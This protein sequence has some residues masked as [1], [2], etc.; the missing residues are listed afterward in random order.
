MM[1][2]GSPLRV[3]ATLDTAN[4]L[5]YAGFDPVLNVH[6]SHDGADTAL[7]N[8]AIAGGGTAT[9]PAAGQ[10]LSVAVE[11]C[12][13]PAPGGPAPLTQIHF[14]SLTPVAG[15]GA[16]VDVTSQPFDLPVCG[17]ATTT[18]AIASASTVTRYTPVNM[19]VGAGGYVD[20]N[21]EGGFDPQFYPSGVRYEVIGAVSGS[22]MPSYI[23][24]GGTNNGDTLSPTSLTATNGLVVNPNEELMLQSTLGTGSDA[25]PLCPGGGAGTTGGGSGSGGGS[26]TPPH[27]HPLPGQPGGPPGVVVTPRTESVNGRRTRVALFCARRDVPCRGTLTLTYGTLTLATKQF[28]SK[29]LATAHIALRLTPAAAKLV[30]SSGPSGLKTTMTVTLPGDTPVG[31]TITLRAR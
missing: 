31:G 13:E 22:A 14:Q 25:T 26:G 28:T 30:R 20:F 11:G 21:D 6:V 15:G 4:N 23:L 3:P 5:G 10:V 8:T 18:G 7:W 16:T 17:T 19:C 2:F 1:T 12:A 24:A 27:P 29:D 9:A